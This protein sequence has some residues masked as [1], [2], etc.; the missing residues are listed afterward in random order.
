MIDILKKLSFMK[1]AEIDRAFLDLTKKY[2]KEELYQ[3]LLSIK[4]DREKERYIYARVL[5]MFYEMKKNEIIQE[6][7]Q[8]A[9]DPSWQVR[10]AVA[11]SLYK[12]LEKDFERVY[13]IF[14]EK[15]KS[16]DVFEKRAIAIAVMRYARNRKNIEELLSLLEPL[17]YE[18]N[19]IIRKILGPFVIGDGFIRYSPEKTFNWLHN[20]LNEDNVW[21][22]WNIAM[23]FTTKESRK[24]KDL[25]M[26]ILEILKKDYR[27]EIQ[28]AVSKA[29]KNLQAI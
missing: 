13:N 8:L 22:R 14:K 21:V 4:N 16:G 26:K 11:F 2:N 29:L 5:W 10:E 28:K 20:L 23:V 6:L 3:Y 12:I 9:R 1:T 27:K 18:E 7:F 19:I 24:Y 15:I 17:M 25:G